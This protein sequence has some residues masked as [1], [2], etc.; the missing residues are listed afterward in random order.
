MRSQFNKRVLFVRHG[1]EISQAPRGS[2][3]D[4]LRPTSRQSLHCIFGDTLPWATLPEK[5]ISLTTLGPTTPSGE[6]IKE[7]VGELL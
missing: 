6:D 7:M 4:P 2:S 5:V 3:Q 1:F